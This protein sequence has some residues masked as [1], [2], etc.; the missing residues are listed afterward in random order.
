M[1]IKRKMIERIRITGGNRQKCID[2]CHR[3]GYKITFLGLIHARGKQYWH[4]AITAERKV[5]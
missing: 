3:H 4:S 2:Y 1:N 5:S